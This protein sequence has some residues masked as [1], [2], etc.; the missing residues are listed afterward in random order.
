MT[1][2]LE[3]LREVLA[4]RYRIEREIGRGGMATVYLA[5]DEHHDRAVALKVLN[6]EFAAPQGA[7]RFQ[8]EI[9]LAAKLQHP[10]ILSVYDSGAADGMA[11]YTMPFVQGESLRD[12]M[13]RE[14]QLPIADAIRIARDVAL[15]LDYAHR[16]GI[17][18]RDIKPENILLSDGQAMVAD[19]GIARA[20]EEEH[21]LT[22]TGIAIGTPAYMSPEQAAGERITDARTDIYALGCVVYEMVAGELPITGPTAA[23]VIARKM[24]ET[25]R[26]LSV[27]R[28]KVPLALAQLVDAMLAIAPADRPAS[29][30]VVATTLDEIVRSS[31]SRTVA[32]P[33]ASRNR[34]SLWI[35]VAAAL[36]L[37][38]FGG[39]A[40]RR[41]RVTPDAALRIAVLP[42][43][44]EGAPTDEYFADGMTDEVRSRLSA[45]PGLEVTA[46]TSTRQYKKSNKPARDI[47]RELSVDYLLTGTVRWSRHAGGP[48]RVRVTPELV[49][50]S[51]NATKWSLPFDTVMSDVFAVQAAIASRVAEN[52]NVALA[53]PT[54]RRLAT[55]PT[56]NLEA[57]HEFL[58]GEELT[59]NVGTADFKVLNAG[60]PH[61][62]R[63]VA[64]DSNFL[65][66]WSSLARSLSYINNSGP[67]VE[68]V[69]RDRVATER[70]MM[71]GAN[72][73]EGQLAFAQYLRDIKL[74]YEG[75]RTH[76]EAGLKIDPNNTDLLLG[77]AG[78]DAILG[79]FD[80]ALARAQHAVKLDPRSLA[81]MRRVPGLLHYLRR[82]PEELAAWD[83]ALALAPDNLGLIQGKAFAYM[84]L[85]ELDSVHALVAEKL[86]TADTTALLVHFALYQE[87]MWVL[88]PELWP[89]IVVLTP[90]DF[91]NDRGHWGLKLGHTY[92]LMGDTAKA[93][94]FGDTAL[95][96]FE[97]QLHDFPDRAQ[98]R[99]LVARAAALAGRKQEAILQ[100]DSALKL[101]ETTNDASLRPYV[102]FQAARVF[103][104]AG[105][106]D[107]ALDLIERLITMP[108]S[109]VT[110]AYL[111]IDPSFAPLKGNPRFEKLIARTAPLAD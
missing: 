13:T 46:R 86:K 54:Q 43:E 47:G 51:S 44:N 82:Y 58:K 9:K 89:K 88:P 91:V 94:M 97:K 50:V 99:E 68:G 72:R 111:R 5:V 18:H 104:Q 74:D 22:Q 2:S 36:C 55:Q 27:V 83:R 75:A 10:H 56:Q 21:A 52:L 11:W 67:T 40:W 3:R 110:A 109:D 63:A 78:V 29:A 61:Y 7:E 108:A 6:A 53:A 25:P 38:I 66:A 96:A 84:S 76:Y 28:T 16:N 41:A 24:T 30:K 87:T 31:A 12:R 90:K 34:R 49:K 60:L 8:R 59:S 101:R 103:I 17:V 95:A 71:L 32:S 33:P 85:G 73:A 23:V 45:V 14:G 69:E 19:L 98:V 1:E 37:G 92:R 105:E 39:I 79:R 106:N 62:E 57:Y 35:A 20:L 4:G 48:D 26:T 100:A 64:L 93:R 42:F 70:A 107:R 81:T 102:L 77:E 15:A 65:E 80:D